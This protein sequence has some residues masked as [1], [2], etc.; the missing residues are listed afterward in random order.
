METFWY[1]LTQVHLKTAIKTG[2]EEEVENG[3][4]SVK[5]MNGTVVRVQRNL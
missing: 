1:W 4:C 3:I 2:K 5:F